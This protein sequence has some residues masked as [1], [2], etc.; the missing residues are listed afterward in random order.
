VEAALDLPEYETF[1][2][3]VEKRENIEKLQ[4]RIEELEE[5]RLA[6]GREKSANSAPGQGT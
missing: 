5:E 1:I 6:R 2:N 3:L 4:M